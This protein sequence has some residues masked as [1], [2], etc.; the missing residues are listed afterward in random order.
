MKKIKTTIYIITV[1]WIAVFTQVFINMIFTNNTKIIEAFAG[2]NSTVLQ[3]EI[4]VI[5]EYTDA[6]LNENDKRNMIDYLATAIGVNTDDGYKTDEKEFTSLMSMTKQSKNAKTTMKVVT[7]TN[8]ETKAIDQYILVNL[9]IYGDINSI[10]K[11]KEIIEDSLK[12]LNV[13]DYQTTIQFSGRYDGRLSLKEMNQIA[14]DLIINLD[15]HIISENREE[16]LFTIYGYTGLIDDYITT[17]NKKVNVNIVMDYD[18]HL[19][20]TTIYLATPII[21]MDY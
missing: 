14:K 15:A 3:S 1:L 21:N 11:Y 19:D 6:Y 8:E 4:Q 18:E 20:K 17:L 5:A 7:L 12:R 13:S 10:V 16:D 9:E 2:T